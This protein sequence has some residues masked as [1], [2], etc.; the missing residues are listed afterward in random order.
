MSQYFKVAELSKLST[1]TI[2]RMLLK[3]LK[4]YPSTNRFEIMIALQDEFRNSR[5]ITTP[6]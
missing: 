5:K 6:E 3:N 2:Y 1:L 4:L